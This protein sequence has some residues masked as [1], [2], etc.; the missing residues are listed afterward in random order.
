[1]EE[2][3]T[4]GSGK[5]YVKEFD[6]SAGMPALADVAVAANQLGWISGGAEIVYTPTVY[7]AKDDLNQVNK[8]IV[9]AETVTMKSGIMTWNGGTLDVLCATARV[10]TTSTN[11]HRIV[12]IGGVGNQKTT[13]YIILF[14]HEDDEEGT[15]MVAIVGYNKAGF[16]LTY[17]M[18]KETVIDA[19][20]TATPHD[21]EGTLVIFDEE[22]DSV[23]VEED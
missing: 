14:V 21:S 1:M 18:D 12:K 23:V 7:E 13:R 11:G 4:L 10:D 20:F 16:T 2:K 8:R 17:A 5:L 15:T 6:A 22:D 3:I 19:E 9:T